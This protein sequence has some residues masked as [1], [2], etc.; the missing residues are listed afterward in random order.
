[1]NNSIFIKLLL[2]NHKRMFLILMMTMFGKMILVSNKYLVPNSGSDEPSDPYHQI[3]C[4]HTHWSA[5]LLF[6]IF[7]IFC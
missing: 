2:Q 1:M 7:Q 3:H 6:G 5:R 4:S